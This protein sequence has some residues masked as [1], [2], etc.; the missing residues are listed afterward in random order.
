MDK[1]E[2][3]QQVETIPPQWI[4][5]S[6]KTVVGTVVDDDEHRC[7]CK[8]VYLVDLWLVAPVGVK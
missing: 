6:C 4:C 2:D 3:N 8:D 1:K 7:N 5:M